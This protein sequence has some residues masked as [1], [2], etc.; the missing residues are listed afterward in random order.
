MASTVVGL[1]SVAICPAEPSTVCVES[2]SDD[3]VVGSEV[4]NVDSTFSP[5]CAECM[6]SEKPECGGCGRPR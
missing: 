4:P 2:Q 3:V 6:H 5:I 1:L